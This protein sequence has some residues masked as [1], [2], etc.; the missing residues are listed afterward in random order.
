M[1]PDIGWRKEAV[2]MH[3]AGEPG[4][5]RMR[6]FFILT[7]FAAG[8]VLFVGR[9]LSLQIA[10]RNYYRELAAP[11]N[12]R[13]V[14][15]E[16][17][18]GELLDRNGIKLVE[19][20]GKN[21]IRLNR[22]LLPRGEENSTLLA[23]IRYM[24][25][26]QVTLEDIMPVED[27][28]PYRYLPPEDAEGK[29]R[30][31]VFLRSAEL[32][33]AE[34]VGEKLYLAA[35]NRYNIAKTVA[36]EATEAEIRKIVGLRY[37][38]DANDFSLTA[39]YVLV[40]DAG[41]EL[42]SGISE[43]LYTMPG[44]EIAVENERYYPFGS[45]AA[46][47]L[48]RTGPI[49]ADEAAL[50]TEKGYALNESVGKDGA[51]RAFESYLR[52]VGG[53][54][55]VVYTADGDEIL[56][57]TVSETSPPSYGKTVM[58]TVSAGMQQAAE[59][60]LKEVIDGINNQHIRDS[61][62]ERASGAVVVT[63]C[64]NGEIYVSASYPTYNQNTYR[65][66]ISDWLN[67]PAQPLLNRAS[68]GIYPPGSTFKIATA[69]A[70]LSCGVIDEN[71]RIYDSGIY[72]EYEGFEPHCWY[73][74]TYGIAHGWQNVVEAI[75]NSCN[76]YFYEVGRLLGTERLNDYA[77]RLGLGEPSGVET[78]EASGILA[79]PE[80][81]ASIGK[82]WQP[83]DLIQSAIGQS[84]NLF[85]PLQLASFFST[86]VN[87]GTRYRLHFL[88]SVN[89]FY[90]GDVLFEQEP[91]ILNTVELAPEHLE[92]LKRGMKSVVEDGT[93]ASVFMNYP[94]PVG[95]KTGTA[96]RG[97]GSDN[98]IFAG[99]APYETPSIVVSVVVEAGEHSSVAATVAKSVFD[100]YFEHI[101]EFEETN[102]E[103]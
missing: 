90:T 35:Y 50:Y 78:G 4:V 54:K 84:D 40:E 82:P 23:L 19:N 6:I 65:T 29:R 69:A 34:I 36:P 94:N 15:I 2:G 46:H 60:S 33:E 61:N 38:L 100:Y 70:A 98:A 73:F 93:A 88:K 99:F 22:G 5:S 87:G 75:T 17:T 39:P 21:V 59:A 63:D 74:D 79:G 76:Y 97:V 85:T 57:E 91:E 92:L 71:T 3:R 41:T 28:A 12:E 42:V 7:L 95:G 1:A 20:R 64:R 58:L 103:F 102:Q 68:Q 32:T 44:V 9:L 89:D 13:T 26:A 45:L 49:Y 25:Q 62:P 31:A 14:Y 86:V 27:S 77:A 83:G 11:K 47:L 51:E 101:G 52:G 80:Y 10:E 43:L 24:E 37:A 30:L 18:R 96:Q 72:R 8:I 16:A 53:Y 66:E 67:D 81:R 48:G 56:S 55:T